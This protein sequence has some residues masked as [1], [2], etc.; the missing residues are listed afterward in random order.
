MS[1]LKDAWPKNEA[2]HRADLVLTSE[3]AGKEKGPS[4]IVAN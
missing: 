2:V 3:L 1:S 4:L